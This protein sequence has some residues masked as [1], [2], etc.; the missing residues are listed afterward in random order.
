M[1]IRAIKKYK[2]KCKKDK[3]LEVEGQELEVKG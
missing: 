1:P 2:S 3:E